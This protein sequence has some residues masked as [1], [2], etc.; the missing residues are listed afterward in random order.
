MPLLAG[1]RKRLL[2]DEDEARKVNSVL[3]VLER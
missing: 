2:N 1:V 3:R